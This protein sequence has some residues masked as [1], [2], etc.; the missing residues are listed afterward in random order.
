[1]ATIKERMSKCPHCG[2]PVM[3]GDAPNV[4]TFNVLMGVADE[5]QREVGM[6]IEGRIVCHDCL[7]ELPVGTT[8]LKKF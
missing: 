5:D 6:S 7:A 2:D 4:G 8:I 3:T 1:M